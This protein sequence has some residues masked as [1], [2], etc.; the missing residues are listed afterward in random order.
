ME[1]V[2]WSGLLAQI[3]GT[4]VGGFVG[5]IVGYAASELIAERRRQKEAD[6]IRAMVR[7][8]ANKI[9]TVARGIHDELMQ[10]Q[11]DQNI[12]DPEIALTARGQCMLGL[13]R[14]TFETRVWDDMK[15]SNPSAFSD[16]QIS[17]LVEFYDAAQHVVTIWEQYARAAS[18]QKTPEYYRDMFEEFDYYQP[19]VDAAL[20]TLIEQGRLLQD[21]LTES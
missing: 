4:G 5:V 8:E 12:T 19:G 6:A 14:P 13:P 7:F 17:A 11:I 2:D 20:A 16:E 9:Q 1:S 21:L 10:N 15:R 3:V 18:S